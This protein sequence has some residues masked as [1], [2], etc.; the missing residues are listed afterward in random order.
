MIRT[1][2]LHRAARLGL[3]P[4]AIGLLVGSHWPRLELVIPDANEPWLDLDKLAHAVAY[5]TLTAVLWWALPPHRG[6]AW[7]CVIT[8]AAVAAFALFD[9]WSQQFVQRMMTA[10]DLAADA[11][12]LALGLAIALRLDA[13]LWLPGLPDVDRR[14][15]AL[16]TREAGGWGLG[17]GAL[18][19]SAAGEAARDT[20]SMDSRLQP[21]APSPPVRP[22]AP[23]A[24]PADAQPPGNATALRH[25]TTVAAATFAS[26]LLGLARDA[27]LMAVLGPGRVLDAFF[28]GFIVPNLFRRLFGEGALTAAFLP[29][30][31][32][33]DDDQRTAYLHAVARRV[34]R[35]VLGL[36]AAG[37]L[38]LLALWLTGVADGLVLGLTAVMLPYAWLV[39]RVALHGAALQ[40]HDR[41]LPAAAAPILLNLGT[42]AAAAVAAITLVDPVQQA[43]AIAAAVVVSGIGQFLYLRTSL[44]RSLPPSRRGSLPPGEPAA[45]ARAMIPVLIALGA[46]QLNALLDGLIAYGFSGPDG[47]IAVGGL[48]RLTAAQRLYQF[49]LGVFG[50]AVATA[51]FPALAAALNKPNTAGSPPPSEAEGCERSELPRITPPE[52][53]SPPDPPLPPNPA[54]TRTLRDA[55]LLSA[56]IALPASAGLI[57]VREPL[58]RVAFQRG[59]FTADDTARVAAIL[60]PYAAAVWAYS[61]NHVLTRGFHARRDTRTPMRISLAMVGLNLALNLALIWPLGIAGMAWATAICAALQCVLLTARTPNARRLADARFRRQAARIAAGTVAMTAT[62]ALLTVACPPDGLI[63]IGSV[64][65]LAAAVLVGVAV[66]VLVALP[67]ADAKI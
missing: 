39:C 1:S 13:L 3:A 31:R 62:L 50:L 56:F 16:P 41:F 25:T 30:Y 38:L 12:G 24:A 64:A 17:T 46:F 42:V 7:R 28:V 51:T 20:A 65:Y 59:A 22:A 48:S 57:L 23:A 36:I 14:G 4:V 21:P 66:H 32:Q 37:E 61:L 45:T 55:L 5:A 67:P 2:Q 47:P 40:A 53:P 54:F 43:H 10:P 58:V 19:Q 33:A 63:W 44:H 26:R 49:P 35:V 18:G 6:R 8:A 11:V 60:I 27:T 29:R 52:S 15:V 9:E 34:G